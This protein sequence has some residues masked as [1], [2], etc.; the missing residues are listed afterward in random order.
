MIDIY[1][2]APDPKQ[3]GERKR[4]HK[5]QSHFVHPWR[6]HGLYVHIQ[7]GLALKGWCAGQHLQTELFAAI[8]HHWHIESDN[9]IR[10]VSFQED[11]VKTKD[12]NYGH[13]LASLRT[14]A[15]RLFREANIQNFRAALDDFNDDPEHFEVFLRQFGFL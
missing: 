9:Y 7:I 6:R 3:C 15:I 13:V 14:L 1:R 5:K 4:L 2:S 12:S 11:H 10:D 8:R